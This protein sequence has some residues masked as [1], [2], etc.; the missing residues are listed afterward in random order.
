[1]EKEIKEEKMTVDGKYSYI[2][3]SFSIYIS[4]QIKLSMATTFIY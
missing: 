2:K 1:M 3:I 4:E